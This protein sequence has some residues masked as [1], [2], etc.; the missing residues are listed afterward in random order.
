MKHIAITNIGSRPS[1]QDAFFESE[2]IFIVCDGVGGSAYGE[3]ASKLA[4]SSFA[5]YF[6]QNP[7]RVYDCNYLNNALQYTVQQFQ[8]TEAKYPETKGMSTTVVLLAA[9]FEGIIIAWL[10]DSRCYHIRNGEVLFVTED[11]S[12]INELAK[13]GQDVSE[14]KRSIITKSL[15]AKTESAFSLHGL[16]KHQIKQGDYFFLCTDG[17]LENITEQKIN[18]LFSGNPVLE[19]LQ[20]NILSECDNKTNDNYTFQIIHT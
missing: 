11:H 15:C 18:Q 19:E 13:Q 7:S 12:L 1:N 6:N 16:S 10:G 20:K 3:V 5:D 14:I 4:C 9:D 2:N 17:V 8:N